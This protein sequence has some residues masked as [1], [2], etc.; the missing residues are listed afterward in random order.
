[1]KRTRAIAL[2]LVVAACTFLAYRLSHPPQP[3]GRLA[4]PQATAT[5]CDQNLWQ[6]VYNPARLQVL[7]PCLSVTGAV[8]AVRNEADGDLHVRF[9][10]DQQ[11]ASLLNQKN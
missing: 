8:D 3:P 1:M 7:S 5:Q 6:Y 11:F 10:L 2:F 4:S 9:R